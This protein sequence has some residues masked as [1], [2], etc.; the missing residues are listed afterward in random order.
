MQFGLLISL[1]HYFL[2][3]LGNQTQMFHN[4]SKYCLESSAIPRYRAMQ[5]S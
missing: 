5:S 1:Q 4:E 2:I 3:H